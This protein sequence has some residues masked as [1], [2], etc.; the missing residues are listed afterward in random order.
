MAKE[1][2]FEEAFNAP[3]EDK[4]KK[5]FSF[6]EAVKQPSAG[7]SLKDLALSFGQG[8]AGTTQSLS[9]LAGAENVVSKKLSGI[10]QLA[11]ETMTPERQAEIQRRQQLEKAAEGNTWEEIKAKLGGVTEAPLQTAATVLGG[12]VPYVA[13]TLAV[14]QAAIPAMIARLT[15]LGMSAK[16]AQKVASAVPVTAIG[17]V[18]GLGGQKSQDYATVKQELLEKDIP[19][20]EAELLA[21]KASEYSLK[22]LPRQAAATAAGGFEGAIGRVWGMNFPYS[23]NN[24]IDDPNLRNIMPVKRYG[25]NIIDGYSFKPRPFTG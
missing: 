21:Q 17:S 25:H 4:D 16:V 5:S 1:F 12:I 11:G 10:Q 8:V 3:K 18:M 7:F 24:Y 23:P 22:N 15:G 2:S 13:G 9:D 14:P 6:Q 19:E 20:N